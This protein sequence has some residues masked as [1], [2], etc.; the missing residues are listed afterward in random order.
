VKRGQAGYSVIEATVSIGVSVAIALA[1]TVFAFQ[2]FYIGGQTRERLEAVALTD[3]VGHWLS[4]DASMADE[5][6]ITGLQA[7][8]ILILK[9]TDWGFGTSN[10]YYSVTYSVEGVQ[11]G[12]GHLNRRYQSSTGIDRTTMVADNV[13]YN[14]NDTAGTTKVAYQTPTLSFQLGFPISTCSEPTSNILT[15]EKMI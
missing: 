1:A 4:N 7:P 2:T 3:T 14:I 12:I 8:A 5:V 11:N 10:V 15:L 6:I 13:Y 9:W